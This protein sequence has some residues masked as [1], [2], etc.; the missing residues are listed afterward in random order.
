MVRCGG[1]SMTNPSDPEVPNLDQADKNFEKIEQ[2][3][4]QIQEFG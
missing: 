3:G 2:E 1:G 4:Y